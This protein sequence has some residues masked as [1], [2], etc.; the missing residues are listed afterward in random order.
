MVNLCYAGSVEERVYGRLLERLEQAQLV[1]GPQQVSLLPV[2]PDDFRRLAER[3]LSEEE[4]EKRAKERLREQQERMKTMQLSPED[5]YDTYVRMTA[6]PGW[7]QAP[8]DRA[9]IWQALVESD[10]LRAVGCNLVESDVPVLEVRGID[11]VAEGVALTCSPELYEEG[12][13]DRFRR[14]HFASY[15]DPAFDAVL[16]HMTQ[17]ELPP[18]VRRIEVPVGLKEQFPVVAY[19]VAC[20]TEQGVLDVRLVRRWTDLEGLRIAED[21]VLDE[22]AVDPWRRSLRQS[23]RGEYDHHEVAQQIEEDNYRSAV[24][25]RLLELAVIRDH[26]LA[27]SRR[28]EARDTANSVLRLVEEMYAERE[29]VRATVP[30]ELF[31]PWSKYLLFDVHLWQLKDHA[32]VITS[33]VLQGAGLD[34]ARSLVASMKRRSGSV[35]V[36]ALL[37]RLDREIEDLRR[38]LIGG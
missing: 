7:L 28:D 16:A 25:Q 26:I 5:L 6:D 35:T 24:L 33:P 10:Y 37:A 2:T 32:E 11:G 3:T 27:C 9:A 19:A 1:V 8:V 20:R 14:L 34:S 29:A 4:L 31:R 22:A 36:R 38:L 15:G 21:A 12:L 13:G 30:A 17:Y 18:C 23:A